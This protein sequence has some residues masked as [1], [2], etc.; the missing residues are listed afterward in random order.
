[1]KL[2][3]SEDTYIKEKAKELINKAKA[4]GSKWQLQIAIAV[5]QA[6]TNGVKYDK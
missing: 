5:V 1:M 2:T 4:K 6:I 3:N